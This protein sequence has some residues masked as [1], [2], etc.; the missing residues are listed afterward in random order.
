NVLRQTDAAGNSTWM[1]YDSGGHIT[2][3]RDPR[4]HDKND[5]RYA[6]TYKYD[7]SHP[8]RMLQKLYPVVPSLPT[9]PYQQ[10][11]FT[12]GKELVLTPAPGHATQPAG[13]VRDE[14]DVN[15]NVTHYQYNWRGD[16]ISESRP[17]GLTLLYSYD[18]I[19]RRI[20]EGKC[21]GVPM[22]TIEFV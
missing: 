6:T 2:A 17:S 14:R 11:S 15:G 7:P 20:G 16:L 4:S 13:L 10:W 12:T 22:C 3:S 21:N 18:N 8:G 9:T 5:N 1:S 19:G